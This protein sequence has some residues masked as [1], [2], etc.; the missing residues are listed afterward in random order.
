MVS[1][2]VKKPSTGLY[3]DFL[4]NGNANAGRELKRVLDREPWVTEC[5]FTEN[6]Q[7]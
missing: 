4:L 6:F 3:W 2:V 5:H 1:R 7:L